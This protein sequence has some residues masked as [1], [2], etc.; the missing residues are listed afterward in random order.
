LVTPWDCETNSLH[1]YKAGF[2][3]GLYS[4]ANRGCDNVLLV[5]TSDYPELTTRMGGAAQALEASNEMRRTLRQEFFED[6]KWKKIGHNVK[7]DENAVWM[8]EG[9]EVAGFY[10]DT[11]FMKFLLNPDNKGF[12]G[13]DDLVKKYC[14]TM[15]HYWTDLMKWLGENAGSTFLDVPASIL[16]PYSAWDAEAT[17]QVYEAQLTELEAMP[18]GWFVYMQDGKP[19]RKSIKPIE[20]AKHGRKIHHLLCTHLERVGQA[21]DLG[22][23]S[24]VKKHYVD[25]NVGLEEIL[26][27]DQSVIEFERAAEPVPEGTKP[28]PR[29]E[30]YLSKKDQKLVKLGGT[31]RINWGSGRHQKGFLLDFLKLPVIKK[32]GTGAPSLDEPVIQAYAYNT[33][34]NNDV[35]K[36]LLEWREGQTFVKSYINP[37]TTGKALHADDK[38]HCS[39]NGASI[40]TGRLSANNPNL[41]GIPRVGP[42]KKLYTSHDQEHGWMV[43][44]DYSNIEVR[45][46]AMVTRDKNLISVFRAGGDPHF[47]TQQYF[48]G[49]AANK[50]DKDQRSICK[51]CLF[52]RL[53]GQEDEGLYGLLSKKGVK[54]PETGEALT[55]AEC[56]TFNAKIDDLYPAVAAWVKVSHAFGRRHKWIGSAFGFVRLLPML[57]Y[58]G[59]M[60]GENSKQM[61]WSLKSAVL[62]DQRRAQNAPIQSSA[63]DLTVFAA[64]KTQSMYREAGLKSVVSSVVH[65]DIWT[66]IPDHNEV[67]LVVAIKSWVMNNPVKWLPELLPGYDCG[68]LD[69]D[70]YGVP[71]VGESEVGI[72]ASDAVKIKKEPL[73]GISD[74]MLVSFDLNGDGK[75][76]LV[77]FMDH[78]K[79]I[80]SRLLAKK[81]LFL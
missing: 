8:Y 36:K 31:V 24:H 70:T 66:S 67:P 12:G 69:P 53:Y 38:V 23:A 33:K 73:L 78:W 22:L 54:N 63:A 76:T 25:I 59:D 50:D 6:P 56:S 27:Q 35:C 79:E 64:W 68:W 47:R 11:L 26:R 58:W 13:L 43:T 49:A 51:Q 42:V 30:H 1:V 21:V 10:M 7:Y 46:L 20:Y 18:G 32:T 9:C 29:L 55:L 4:F 61:P 39:W 57:E 34:Y 45:I 28:K 16:Y 44:R 5:P 77:P 75:S 15:P 72:N 41:T 80:K 71:L 2:R 81:L 60:V 48:F 74:E 37:I 62:K 52:G 65:D 19:I 14:D 17:L 3:I 40:A